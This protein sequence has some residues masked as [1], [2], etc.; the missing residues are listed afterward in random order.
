MTN[1]GVAISDIRAADAAGGDWCCWAGVSLNAGAAFDIT[2]EIA[3]GLS[4]T[5]ADYTLSSTES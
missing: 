3:L 1:E 2:V 4:T 5:E